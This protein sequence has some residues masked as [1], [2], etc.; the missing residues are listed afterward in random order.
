MKI[1]ARLL[2]IGDFIDVAAI[3]IVVG[4]ALLAFG[5]V[6]DRRRTARREAFLHSQQYHDHAR[7]E[8]AARFQ[9][10]SALSGMMSKK[11]APKT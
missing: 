3:V 1:A 2:T 11:H 9:W 10:R 6:R 7:G 4:C 8:L 5:K